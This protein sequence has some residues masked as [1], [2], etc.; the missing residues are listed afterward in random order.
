MMGV[1]HRPVVGFGVGPVAELLVEAGGLE[2]ERIEKDMAAAALHRAS[3][4]RLHQAPA[5]VPTA[6]R[7]ADPEDPDIQ[8]TAPDRAE[9]AADDLV[10]PVPEEEI[11]R[12]VFAEAGDRDV[13]A[14]E[15]VHHDLLEAV[16]GVG[17]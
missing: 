10:A 8:D 4:G 14:V 6:Q 3:L 7:L 16:G 9:E 1:P 13:V 5:E 15:M 17:L 12:R 11:D 2:A